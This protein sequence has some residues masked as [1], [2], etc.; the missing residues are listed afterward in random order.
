[1]S[2]TKS[3]MESFNRVKIF[4]IHFSFFIAFLT[5][6]GSQYMQHARYIVLQSRFATEV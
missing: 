1:M 2:N 6:I 5:G 4:Q 3:A